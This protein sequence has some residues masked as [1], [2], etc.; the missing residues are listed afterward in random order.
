MDLKFDQ[1]ENL[2]LLDN[3]PDARGPDRL[4]RVVEGRHYGHKHLFGGS[5]RRP[6]QGWDAT[7]PGHLPYLSGTGEAASGLINVSPPGQ[8]SLLKTIWNESTLEAATK[9]V[10]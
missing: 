10:Y 6:F 7:F 3:D 2:M 1:K 4:L 8:H 5:G 9:N